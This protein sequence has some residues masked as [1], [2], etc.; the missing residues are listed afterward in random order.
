[1]QDNKGLEF[2]WALIPK[3]TEAILMISQ[4]LRGQAFKSFNLG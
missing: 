1:M 4:H 2:N 3:K